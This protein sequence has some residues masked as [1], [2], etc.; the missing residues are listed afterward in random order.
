[1]AIL[2][3]GYNL[4]NATGID[5]RGTAGRTELERSRI[6]LLNFLAHALTDDERM[7]TTIVFDAKQAPPGLPSELEHAD[8]QIR[9]ARGY[10]AADDLLE[11]LIA[12]DHVPRQL[13]VVSSDHR[14]HK[15]A[16]RR[17]ATAL[18]SDAWIVALQRRSVPTRENSPTASDDSEFS[19]A[20]DP[21]WLAEFG[22]IDVAAIE[23]EV[24]A[25]SPRDGT[26]DTPAFPAD[27]SDSRKSPRTP[28]RKTD[29]E[30]E[31][32]NDA[33]SIFPPE[34]FAPPKRGADPQPPDD[35]NP[36]PAG[37][38]EDIDADDR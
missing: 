32:L 12:A 16:R 14:L 10:P 8:M 19:P 15:A 36:F 20:I 23:A 27:D 29:D 28:P 26:T 7:Q 22:G 17:R 4:L 9:F 34:F 18:D 24:Q 3:D 13:V 31:L 25:E 11:E 38:G 6:A 37:Y 35:W 1:M 21:H 33:R 2:I 30:D 5:G